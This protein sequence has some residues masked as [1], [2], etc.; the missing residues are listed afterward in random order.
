MGVQLPEGQKGKVS[1][2]TRI[3][4]PTQSDGCAGG[5]EE[6]LLG[7]PR[8]RGSIVRI[9]GFDKHDDVRIAVVSPETACVRELNSLRAEGHRYLGSGS[10]TIMA[11]CKL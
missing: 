4:S 2:L 7:K 5:E 3:T 6:W 11:E 1:W 8:S 10:L 9:D